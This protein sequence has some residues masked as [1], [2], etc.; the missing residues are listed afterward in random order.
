MLRSIYKRVTCAKVECAAVTHRKVN[1]MVDKFKMP[2][3]CNSGVLIKVVNGKE[4]TRDNDIN[5]RVFFKR[6]WKQL[7]E[8]V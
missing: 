6:K 1:S 7:E 8:M 5:P 4:T 2:C 3:N